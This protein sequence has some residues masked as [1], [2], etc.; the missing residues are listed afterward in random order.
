MNIGAFGENFPYSNFHDLNMDWIIKIA[1]DFLDQY[2]HIQEVISDGEETLNDTIAE[3]INQLDEKAT[4]IE[5]LLNDWYTTHSADIASELAS[6]ISDLN[7]WYTLHTGYLDAI[8]QENVNTFD[9][10]ATQKANEVIASIPDDYSA[11]SAEVDLL[12]SN[13]SST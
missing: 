1:K 8:L 5:N 13:A 7:S 6:A 9:T 2:T 3:G 4:D 11:L 12:S 10:H